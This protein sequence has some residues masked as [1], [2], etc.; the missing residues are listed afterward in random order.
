VITIPEK[1]DFILELI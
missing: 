1:I